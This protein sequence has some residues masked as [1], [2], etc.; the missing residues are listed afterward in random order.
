M[1]RLVHSLAP[2]IFLLLSGCA[3]PAVAP[4]T[5]VGGPSGIITWTASAAK[6]KAVRGVDEAAVFYEGTSFVIWSDFS[7][8][9]GSS[10]SGSD[11]MRC[12]GRVL[13]RDGRKVAFSCQT[14]DGKTGPVTVGESNYDLKDGNLFLVTYDGERLRVSQLKRDLGNLQFTRDELEA[15]ARQDQELV[16]FFTKPAKPE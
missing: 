13:A 1:T 12:R 11:G 15:F 16:G 5:N 4:V 7:G 14:K 8:G 9:G 2:L 3:R 6:E 10:S